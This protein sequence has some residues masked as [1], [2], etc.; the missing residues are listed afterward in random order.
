M[1]N[2]RKTKHRRRNGKLVTVRHRQY[3]PTGNG[4]GADGH[5][6]YAAKSFN[7]RFDKV[8]MKSAIDHPGRPPQEDVISGIGG[9]T[10]H[11][12]N[13]PNKGKVKY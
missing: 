12:E 2:T 10:K 13:L 11:K 5:P 4:I 6:V 8:K 9:H 7:R 3:P 1:A